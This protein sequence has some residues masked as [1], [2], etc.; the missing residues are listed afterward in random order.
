MMHEYHVKIHVEDYETDVVAESEGQA[1]DR[2]FDELHDHLYPC[3][4]EYETEKMPAEIDD[5]MYRS[6]F[7]YE[8]RNGVWK[9]GVA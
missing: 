1:E 2:A 5:E 7:F 8:I 9:K 3:D 4:C 6:G